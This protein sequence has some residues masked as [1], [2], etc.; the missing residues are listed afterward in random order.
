MAPFALVECHFVRWRTRDGRYTVELVRLSM[1]SRDGDGQW[2]RL[3]EHGFHV[4]DVRTPDE[5][6]EFI[7]LADLDELLSLSA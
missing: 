2:I 1:T 6:A 7:D 5:L 3:K 4:A